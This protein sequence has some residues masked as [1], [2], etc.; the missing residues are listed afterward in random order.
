MNLSTQPRIGPTLDLRSS[1]HLLGLMR[2]EGACAGRPALR[3]NLHREKLGVD[4]RLEC[5]GRSGRT[6]RGVVIRFHGFIRSKTHIPNIGL[7][8]ASITRMAFKSFMTSRA[9]YRP[10]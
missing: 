8:H 1:D 9:C 7:R 3:N 2:I 10:E 4:F 5:P 6:R